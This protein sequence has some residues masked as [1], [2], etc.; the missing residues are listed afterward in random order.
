MR[1][2]L[3][4]TA[5]A[6]VLAAGSVFGEENAPFRFPDGSTE[7]RS[8]NGVLKMPVPTLSGAER[9]VSEGFTVG[10]PTNDVAFLDRSNWM[11]AV[12][13]T[14]IRDDYRKDFGLIE[15]RVMPLERSVAE[16]YGP[17]LYQAR[18]ALWGGTRVLETL[19]FRPPIDLPSDIDMLRVAGPGFDGSNKNNQRRADIWFVRNGYM[20]QIVAVTNDTTKIPAEQLMERAQG[21]ARSA[22]DKILINS[23]EVPN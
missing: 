11:L 10:D 17:E 7:Y 14:R 4:C 5:A 22:F 1:F 3:A 23:E 6:I 20:I 16:K 13:Y 2:L 12:I 15:E 19:N 9:V 8:P 21:I 18:E